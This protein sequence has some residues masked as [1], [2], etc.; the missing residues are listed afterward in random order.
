VSRVARGRLLDQGDIILFPRSVPIC[1]NRYTYPPPLS[2]S[3]VYLHRSILNDDPSTTAAA[4]GG[5]RVTA[6]IPRSDRLSSHGPVEEGGASSP[7][8]HRGPFS[9]EPQHGSCD[10]L[11]GSSGRAARHDLILRQTKDIIFINKPA[12]VEVQGP[13]GDSIEALMRR[14][15]L[16]LD[17]SDDLKCVTDHDESG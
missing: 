5:S 7:G 4:G 9:P 12:G 2:T 15:E 13:A 14:G 6:S 8:T 16:S 10:N 1:S 3:R 11:V 17:P